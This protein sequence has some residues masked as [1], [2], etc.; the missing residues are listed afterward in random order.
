[1]MYGTTEYGGTGG[2]SKDLG[3]GC[4]KRLGCG[5]VFSVDPAGEK[6]VIYRFRGGQR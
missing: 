2:C 1:M 5:T 3:C 4:R 6:K